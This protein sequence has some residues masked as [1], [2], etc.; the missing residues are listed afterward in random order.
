MAITRFWLKLRRNQKIPR[1]LGIVKQFQVSR[2]LIPAIEGCNPED[3]LSLDRL[4][5]ALRTHA[6]RLLDI[7]L[8]ARKRLMIVLSFSSFFSVHKAVRIPLTLHA[9]STSLLIDGLSTLRS[10]FPCIRE[11]SRRVLR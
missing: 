2:N 7:C 1:I 6:S 9:R 10:K 4:G 8:R 11:F 3:T 5:G